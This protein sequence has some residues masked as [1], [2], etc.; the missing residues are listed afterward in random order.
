MSA[1]PGR[2]VVALGGNALLK[3]G[4]RPSSDAQRRNVRVAAAVIADLAR[5]R[6]PETGLV[7]THGN[8]PQVG[9]LARQSELSGG[10]PSPLDELGA[11]TQGMIGY[12]VE[13]ELRDRL[14]DGREVATLLTQV[15]VDAGDPAFE[16]PTKPI[17]T[18]LPQAQAESLARA[19]GWTIALDGEQW[20]R[21]VP[22]PEPIRILEQRSIELLLDAGVVVVCAGGGGVPVVPDPAGGWRGVEAVVDKDL[23]SALLAQAID[24]EALL[25]LT[26]VDAV[27]RDFGRDTAR[28]IRCAT[29]AELRSEHFAPGSMGPKVEAACRFIE[30]GRG[31]AP[32][33][34]A[35]GAL[36]DAARILRGEAGT[37]V[38][39]TD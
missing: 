38:V 39:A 10:L 6:G 11:Q 36:E 20:R 1:R 24:A 21:V 37:R 23:S 12:L 34:A 4:E 30:G 17:G 27:Y 5:H 18:A 16:R 2:L 15:A 9:L 14:P 28:A 25:L 35:I 8:G 29:V 31:R 3:R 13:D 33:L 19:R 22:S 32:R 26:D 7:V